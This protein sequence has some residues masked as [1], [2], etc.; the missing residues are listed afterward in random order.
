L[1]FRF[2]IDI[3]SPLAGLVDPRQAFIVFCL[4]VIGISRAQDGMRKFSSAVVET[5]AVASTHV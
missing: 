4:S 3:P 1:V 2:S 5:S